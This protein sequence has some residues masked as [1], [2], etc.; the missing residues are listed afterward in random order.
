MSAS[1]P[2]PPP[3]P[4]FAPYPPY[5]P[6]A[7]YPANARHIHR[8]PSSTFPSAAGSGIG[9][10]FV[11]PPGA[12]GQASGAAG[13]GAS[14]SPG[15]QTLPISAISLGPVPGYHSGTGLHQAAR[16][17]V[18]PS[19]VPGSAPLQFAAHQTSVT[20]MLF[21]LNEQVV[22]N[23]FGVAVPPGV[24]DFSKA[25]I[26]FHPIPGQAGYL[27]SDYP[28]KS[29]KWPQLFY[30]MER[31]GYQVDRARQLGA[32]PNQI[33]I[34]PFLTS[35]ATDTGIFP[36]RW[37]NIVIDVLTSVRILTGAGGSSLIAISEVTVSSFS[38]GFVYSE[39]FR[40]TATGIQPLMSQVW[41][42]DGYPKAQSSALTG[43][44]VIKYDLASEPGSIHLPSP[45]WANLS[46]T[47]QPPNQDDSA[48]TEDLHHWVLKYMYLPAAM[49]FH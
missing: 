45:R 17:M 36:N 14:G 41:D 48:V 27:D 9:S 7:P 29:G 6:Y 46:S 23:W 49:Q 4:P 10:A 30:Y 28:T 16:L 15:Q 13:G 5:A 38:V 22:P 31:L 47:P 11:A 37:K 42:F 1:S 24:T 39:S 44:N 32:T 34:M 19:T 21:A 2:S 20:T 26:F 25:H 43:P 3:F 12:D 33:V 35:A 8:P 18:D 40:Q